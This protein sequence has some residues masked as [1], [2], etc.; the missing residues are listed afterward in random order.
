M[1]KR[2]NCKAVISMV[3]CMVMIAG[4]VLPYNVHAASKVV[5]LVSE[6]EYLSKY[7]NK[8][9]YKA[10]PYYRYAT[11]TKE[12]KTSGYSSLEGWTRS[13]RELVS[14]EVVKNWRQ[15]L[16]KPYLQAEETV[17]GRTEN[18]EAVK[19]RET[20]DNVWTY[21]FY[22]CKHKTHYS[23]DSDYSHGSCKTDRWVVIGTN[24]P[25]EEFGYP[26]PADT[27]GFTLWDHVTF[28]VP[29]SFSIDNPKGFGKIYFILI[30][31]E[32]IS[33]WT[34]NS[35]ST[36]VMCTGC[37]NWY[38][39][40]ENKYRYS[41]WR[42]SDWSA[43]SDWT[44]DVRSTGDTCKK[45]STV[46][47]Y[48]TD[49]RKAEQTISGKSSYSVKY[50][51]GS[52]NLNCSTN[53]DSILKYSSSN[54]NVVSVDSNGYVTVKGVGSAAITVTAS[55]TDNYKSAQKT[56]QITV[57]KKKQTI[58]GQTRYD[59]TYGD[60]SFNLNCS[61]DG[62]GTLEYSSS[63]SN[64][65]SVDAY[66]D[67]WIKRSGSAAITVVASE[68]GTH[69][70][71]TKTID[72]YV[73]KAAQTINV[74]DELVLWL[75]DAP[76][77]LGQ[78]CDSGKARYKVYNKNIV[79]ASSSGIV[80]AKKPGKTKIYITA[81]S[82][83]KYKGTHKI[84]CVT[85]KLKTPQLECKNNYGKIKFTWNK[86]PGASGYKVYL[87][88]KNKK[89]YICKMTKKSSQRSA[90]IREPKIGK[91]YKVAVRA[92]KNVNGKK[93]YGDYSNNVS[94]IGK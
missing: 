56:I 59:K 66:G 16:L 25:F 49:I 10:V 90:V 83:S 86:V 29:K 87:Y 91:E 40:L 84:V 52:F 60:S 82:D 7:T 51:A 23:E 20:I 44:A 2:I 11:R 63:N 12:T 68:T 62:D 78:I 43:W 74:T 58:S 3:L 64:V 1:A 46:M 27:T 32:S 9:D 18:F 47:Y 41:Y 17:T 69:S 15:N 94:V 21:G 61:T 81:L 75:G 89:K 42:W 65:V 8:E 85:V 38:R 19:I 88:D 80:K 31:G 36:I 28:E 72:I 67:V 24:K 48:V 53:G 73:S 14:S 34:S 93:V 39:E 54:S 22:T 50:G 35:D 26:K 37:T 33:E 70:S 45:D 79:T 5:G 71:A 6:D 92:Y 30:E 55:E 57:A 4:I 13:G 77:D 76:Y